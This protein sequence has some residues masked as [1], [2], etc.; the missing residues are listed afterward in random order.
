MDVGNT[1]RRLAAVAGLRQVSVQ[2]SV[3]MAFHTLHSA[4]SV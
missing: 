3:H 2:V 1:P 4:N